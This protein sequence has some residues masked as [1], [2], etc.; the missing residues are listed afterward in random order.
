MAIVRKETVASGLNMSE[1]FRTNWG[2]WLGFTLILMLGWILWSMMAP[3]APL[4]GDSPLVQMAHTW[5]E[6]RG[7]WNVQQMNVPP[8]Y[9]V[10][11]AMFMKFMG[12][13]HIGELIHTT[14]HPYLLLN[15]VLYIASAIQLFFIGQTLL[16]RPWY[17]IVAGL[18]AISPTT[19][20]NATE[21]NGQ[22]LFVVLTLLALQ[23]ITAT[24]VDQGSPVSGWQRFW[25][26]LFMAVAIMTRNL[27]F[28][29]PM[30][31]LVMMAR[32]QE[33]RLGVTTVGLLLAILLPWTM[34]E[35]YLR[36]TT[37]TPIAALNVSEA[38]DAVPNSMG[39]SRQ[40]FGQVLKKAEHA[41]GETTEGT[42]GNFSLKRLEG[43]LFKRLS[44]Y[45]VQIPL[46]EFPLVKWMMGGL[47]AAGIFLGLQAWPGAF[48][49]YLICYLAATVFFPV[50]SSNL[51][52][53]VLPLLLMHLFMGV[54][55]IGLWTQGFGLDVTRYLLP[56]LT[57]IIM[58]NDV[59]GH[60]ENIRTR[61]LT[62]DNQIEL[63]AE[64]T[65][66]IWR[67]AQWLNTHARP[68]SRIMTIKHEAFSEWKQLPYPRRRAS[69]TKLMQ[70]LTRADYIVD[71]PGRQRDMLSSLIQK[72]PSN[73]Q[74]VY[75][76]NTA[77]I[78][79]WRVE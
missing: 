38:T 73:F 69:V 45:R 60:L 49:L 20:Q 34:W 11:L 4:A 12:N 27:G 32:R 9:P 21:P 36:N 56:A 62:L 70:Q 24:Y 2:D 3:H 51:L 14:L 5:G 52:M 79:I 10:V 1:W 16:P 15:L 17:W 67:A 26:C 61:K 29:L 44:L 18:Y 74:N 22:M 50:E 31:Y 39:E 6:M 25:C 63:R 58:I 40:L 7:H 28:V 23:T 19:L 76:D 55:Q 35:V 46:S 37:E 75:D 72:Y 57:G 68:D 65:R 13:R 43:G 59:N 30:V 47:I 66:P 48:S 33:F 64:E 41:I 42:L 78:R 54:M 77:K 53:P 8:G 71:V